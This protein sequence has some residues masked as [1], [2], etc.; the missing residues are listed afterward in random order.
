MNGPYDD[1]KKQAQ[2]IAASSNLKPT[3]H[4]FKPNTLTSAIDYADILDI[5]SY[6]REAAL[7]GRWNVLNPPEDMA[8]TAHLEQKK[9]GFGGAAWRTFKSSFGDMLDNWFDMGTYGLNSGMAQFDNNLREIIPDFDAKRQTI[10]QNPNDGAARFKLGTGYWAMQLGNMG[11]TA[12]MMAGMIGEQ[13]VLWSAT[14]ALTGITGVGG[15]G[16]AALAGTRAASWLNKISKIAKVGLNVTKSIGLPFYQGV[17]EAYI[18]GLEV[19]QEVYTEFLNKP[20]YTQ[21]QALELAQQAVK[22]QVIREGAITG[23]INA[24]QWGALSAFPAMKLGKV[25]TPLERVGQIAGKQSGGRLGQMLEL[26]IGVSGGIERFMGLGIDKIGHRGLRFL[27]KGAINMGSEAIEEGVQNVISNW[28]H[29]DILKQEGFNYEH[30]KFVDSQTIDEMIGGALGGALFGI[31]GG[32]FTKIQNIA[33][34]KAVREREAFLKEKSDEMKNY[35]KEFGAESLGL[36]KSLGTKYTNLIQQYAEATKNKD[37]SRALEIADEIKDVKE[38]IKKAQMN[39]A[40]N[41]ALQ[42]IVADLN[43]QGTENSWVE[44]GYNQIEAIQGALEEYIKVFDE[45]KANNQNNPFLAS[46]LADNETLSNAVQ[47]LKSLE[48]LDSNNLV[49]DREVLTDMQKIYGDSKTTFNNAIEN[50]A[51]YYDK[52]NADTQMAVDYTKENMILGLYEESIAESNTRLADTQRELEELKTKEEERKAKKGK[53]K[54]ANELKIKELEGTIEAIEKDISAAEEF[55]DAVGKDIADL[56]NPKKFEEYRRKKMFE[57]FDLSDMSK[58][59]NKYLKEYVDELE[60]NAKTEDEKA[61]AEKAREFLDRKIK[62]EGKKGKKE[63]KKQKEAENFVGDDIQVPQAVVTEE[64]LQ[65][66]TTEEVVVEEENLEA[67]SI[68]EEQMRIEE[69]ASIIDDSTIEEIDTLLRGTADILNRGINVDT[70]KEQLVKLEE[71]FETLSDINDNTYNDRI[72]QL[73]YYINNINFILI[74]D[75]NISNMID[76]SLLSFIKGFIPNPSAVQIRSIIEN[77]TLNIDGTELTTGI[78]NIYFFANQPQLKEIVRNRIEKIVKKDQVE[79]SEQE[80]V[81]DEMSE[82]VDVIAESQATWDGEAFNIAFEQAFNMYHTPVSGNGINTSTKGP[83]TIYTKRKRGWSSKTKS[84]T[85]TMTRNVMQLT[86]VFDKIMGATEERLRL[87]GIKRTPTFEDYLETCSLRQDTEFVIEH[88]AMYADMWNI[89]NGR[90]D[91]ATELIGRINEYMLHVQEVQAEVT[92]TQVEKQVESQEQITPQIESK[93][94][95]KDEKV[96]P[97]VDVHSVV[98][99]KEQIKKKDTRVAFYFVDASKNQYVISPDGKTKSTVR[100]NTLRDGEHFILD[101]EFIVDELAKTN[102]NLEL[103][104][105]IPTAEDLQKHKA[106]EYPT[107]DGQGVPVIHDNYF[108]YYA[109]LGINRNT[110]ESIFLPNLSTPDKIPHGLKSQFGMFMTSIPM[111]IKYESNEGP[112][113]LGQVRGLNQLSEFSVDDREKIIAQRTAL[114]T[115]NGK[116]VLTGYDQ[117]SVHTRETA[118]FGNTRSALKD[119][120]GLTNRIRYTSKVRNIDDTAAPTVVINNEVHIFELF[121]DDDGRMRKDRNGLPTTVIEDGYTYLNGKKMKV[122][123]YMRMTVAEDPRGAKTSAVDTYEKAYNHLK[124]ASIFTA[125][126]QLNQMNENLLNEEGKAIIAFVQG[127]P[128]LSSL[129]IQN[130]SINKNN[131]KTI[132]GQVDTFLTNEMDLSSDGTKFVSHFNAFLNYDVDTKV[133]QSQKLFSSFLN[134]QK[135]HNIQFKDSSG[136]TQTRT[137]EVMLD[138]IQ[139]L[140]DNSDTNPYYIGRFK[141]PNTNKLFIKLSLDIKHKKGENYG[142]V[143]GPAF[144]DFTEIEGRLDATRDSDGNM[145][146]LGYLSDYVDKWS[147]NQKLHNIKGPNGHTTQTFGIQPKVYYEVMSKDNVK[148]ETNAYV[149][150]LLKGNKQITPIQPATSEQVVQEVVE[151]MVKPAKKKEVTPKKKTIKPVKQGQEENAVGQIVDTSTKDTYTSLVNAVKEA[152]L[153]NFAEQVLENENLRII[154]HGIDNN[155]K[156]LIKQL[157]EVNGLDAELLEYVHAIPGNEVSVKIESIEGFN[158]QLP[159][160]DNAVNFA[161]DVYNLQGINA[162]DQYEL[163]QSLVPIV[164]QQYVENHGAETIKP[165]LI[166]QIVSGLTEDIAQIKEDTQKKFED[167]KAEKKFNEALKVKSYINTLNLL[168]EDNINLLLSPNGLLTQALNEQIVVNLIEEDN[169]FEVPSKS[170]DNIGKSNLERSGENSLSAAARMVLASIKTDKVNK[171]GLPIYENAREVYDNLVDVMVTSSNNIDEVI[172][173]VNIA[174]QQA[175]SLQ[176]RNIYAQLYKILDDA[177]N[178]KKNIMSKKILNGLIVKTHLNAADM[179]ITNVKINKWSD[180]MTGE[181]NEET[182]VQ[183]WNA[184]LDDLSVAKMNEM[185]DMFYNNHETIIF[186]TN[187]TTGA[188]TSQIAWDNNKLRSTKETLEGLQNRFE[189]Q[190]PTQF[191]R[192]YY[193]PIKLLIA[194]MGFNISDSTLADNEILISLFSKDKKD[195]LGKLI[196]D[197]IN[198]VAIQEGNYSVVQEGKTKVLQN[199]NSAF[200]TLMEIESENEGHI[201]T[202]AYIGEKLLSGALQSTEIYDRVQQLKFALDQNKTNAYYYTLQKMQTAKNHIL[203]AAEYFRK[204]GNN[205]AL[206]NLLDTFGPIFLPPEVIRN[207]EIKENSESIDKLS[208]QEYLI[209]AF[210]YLNQI[211]KTQPC[212]INGKD[213]GFRNGYIFL[214]TISDKGQMVAVQMPLLDITGADSTF[215]IVDGKL[216]LGLGNN[217][218]HLLTDQLFKSEVSRM[219]HLENNKKTLTSKTLIKSNFFFTTLEDFNNVMVKNEKKEIVPLLSYLQSNPHLNIAQVMALTTEEGMNVNQRVDSIVT[220]YFNDKLDEV[221][222]V[223]LNKKEN[224]AVL[225]DVKGV[226]ADNGLVSSQNGSFKYE[227]MDKKFLDSRQVKGDIDGVKI[228]KK[229]REVMLTSMDAIINNVLGQKTI[230]DLFMDSATTFVKAVPEFNSKTTSE[231][232]QAQVSESYKLFADNLKKRMAMMIAP[233]YKQMNSENFWDNTQKVMNE[234]LTLS[235]GKTI[236]NKL[237]KVI[238]VKDRIKVSDS[239]GTLIKLYYKDKIG[240][241]QTKIDELDQLFINIQDLSNR[242]KDVTKL[243][244]RKDKIV[245][246]LKAA[247]PKIAAFCEIDSSDGQTYCTWNQYLNFQYRM[248]EITMEDYERLDEMMTRLEAGERYSKLKVEEREFL[249]SFFMNSL[250]T[251][252]TGNVLEKDNNG[253]SIATKGYYIKTSVFPLLP[254]FTQGTKLDNVRKVM[255]AT[256]TQDGKNYIPTLLT[257]DSSIKAGNNI[258]TINYAT[259]LKNDSSKDMDAINKAT[260]T[261]NS[262]YYRLQQATDTHITDFLTKGQQQTINEGVQ[263]N[264]LK[265]SNNIATSLTYDMPGNEL[266]QVIYA[267]NKAFP[268]EKMEGLLDEN[269]NTMITGNMLERLDNWL[270]KKRI[271][272]DLDRLLS[273]LKGKTEIQ[274]DIARLNKEKKELNEQFRQVR[275]F[276]EINDDIN[277]LKEKRRNAYKSINQWKKGVTPTIVKA[278]EMLREEIEKDTIKL[279][280]LYDES[281]ERKGLVSQSENL[282]ERIDELKSLNEVAKNETSDDTTQAMYNL[283]KDEIIKRKLPTNLLEQIKIVEHDGKKVFNVSLF[284][285][286][287]QKQ[288]SDLLFSL[289][290]NSVIQ[291][292]LPGQAHYVV[293]SSELISKRKAK[294]LSQVEPNEIVFI[295]DHSLVNGELGFVEDKVTG[296]IKSQ[297]LLP[298]HFS[299]KQP[300]GTLK[301]IDLFDKEGEW[302]IEKDGRYILNEEKFDKS[303]LDMFTFRIPSSSSAMAN[304]VE[305]VGFIPASYGDIAIVNKE[306]IK[307]LGEDFDIDKRYIYKHYFD[308]KD[309]KFSKKAFNINDTKSIKNA[310]ID[311]YHSVYNTTNE[312]FK[313]EFHKTL[314]TD[315][316]EATANKIAELSNKNQKNSYFDMLYNMKTMKNGASALTAV[317]VFALA[318]KVHALYNRGGGFVVNQGLVVPGKNGIKTIQQLYKFTFGNKTVTD[319]KI[320]NKLAMD[321]VTVIADLFNADLQSAVDNGKLGIIEKI[322]LTNHTINAYLFLNYIGANPYFTKNDVQYRASQIFLAQPILRR[323]SQLMENNNS[324]FARS[325]EADVLRTLISEQGIKIDDKIWN[326]LSY[327]DKI[328]EIRWNLLKFFKLATLNED[329]NLKVRQWELTE[330]SGGVST[331][332]DNVYSTDKYHEISERLTAD[333]LYNQLENGAKQHTQ[334]FALVKFMEFNHKGRQISDISGLLNR[335]KSTRNMFDLMTLKEDLKV[336]FKSETISDINTMIGDVTEYAEE[337]GDMTNVYNLDGTWFRI[338]PITTEGSLIMTLIDAAE[339]I[340]EPHFPYNSR[341]IS[342]AMAD[343]VKF[344]W[345]GQNKN[346][347]KINELRKKIVADMAKFFERNRDANLANITQIGYDELIQQMFKD[348]ESNESFPMFVAKIKHANLS[349]T[350]NE[351]LKPFMIRKEDTKTILKTNLINRDKQT[352]IRMR[353]IFID[354][355]KDNSEIIDKDGN[356]IYWNNEKLTYRQLAQYFVL[357]SK[358]SNSQGGAIGFSNI[359]PQKYLD[360]VGFPKSVRNI[361]SNINS[362]L[363]GIKVPSIHAYSK[364]YAQHHPDILQDESILVNKGT[365]ANSEFNYKGKLWTVESIMADTD[366]SVGLDIKTKV[367]ALEYI[368]SFQ[369]SEIGQGTDS[370]GQDIILPFISLKTSDR[371]YLIFE[372]DVSND[373]GITTWKQ[374]STL[375]GFGVSEYIFN[376]N[377]VIGMDVKGTLKEHVIS[378]VLE[379]VVPIQSVKQDNTVPQTKEMKEIG[380]MLGKLTANEQTISLDKFLSSKQIQG[381]FA[382]EKAEMLKFLQD[383]GIDD[384]I[385]VPFDQNHLAYSPDSI[386]G[387]L[388]SKFDAARS[389]LGLKYQDVP[390]TAKWDKLNIDGKETYVI[391]I[392]TPDFMKSINKEVMADIILEEILHDGIGREFAKYNK[393]EDMPMEM[394]VS[395]NLHQNFQKKFEKV[396]S[397]YPNQYKYYTKDI[398]EFSAA[399]ELHEDFRNAVNEVMNDESFVDKFIRAFKSF[400]DKL[401]GKEQNYTN[402]VRDTTGRILSKSYSQNNNLYQKYLELVNKQIVDETANFQAKYQELVDL[403]QKLDVLPIATVDIS[404]Q[405]QIQETELTIELLDDV[406]A[407]GVQ[408]GSIDYYNVAGFNIQMGN[409]DQFGHEAIYQYREL[410]DKMLGRTSRSIRTLRNRARQLGNNNPSWDT[411]H[412]SVERLMDRQAAIEKE[413]T[414]VEN[415]E[416]GDSHLFL[417]SVQ[418]EIFRLSENIDK[419]SQ[420]NNEFKGISDPH[421]LSDVLGSFQ[422]IKSFIEELST[423][424]T[425][426]RLSDR[427]ND[428]LVDAADMIHKT[429]LKLNSLSEKLVYHLLL[430]DNELKQGIFKGL[431]NEELKQALEKIIQEEIT[432]N[433]GTNSFFDRFLG[434]LSSFKHDL[435]HTQILGKYI[436]N[437]ILEHNVVAKSYKQQMKEMADK[438]ADFKDEKFLET[439][440]GE[441]TGDLIDYFSP[442]WK[443]QLMYFESLSYKSDDPLR[444][445]NDRLKWL[446]DKHVIDFRRIPEVRD[447]K[448]TKLDGSETTFFEKYNGVYDLNYEDSAMNSYV[449]ELKQKLGKQYDFF[450]R[451]VINQLVE[452]ERYNERLT[453]D[454][455]FEKYEIAGKASPWLF[456]GTQFDKEGNMLSEAQELQV[457]IPFENGTV[458][459]A[460]F[461]SEMQNITVIPQDIPKYKNAQFDALTDAELDLWRVLRDIYANH[462]N[463]IYTDRYNDDLS[464]A[465]IEQ[466]TFETFSKYGMKKG[467][468][469]LKAKGKGAF[470][471]S[472]YKEAGFNV[473]KNYFDSTKSDIAEMIEIL[474]NQN[475]NYIETLAK[476]YKVDETLNREEQIFK[477]AHRANLGNFSTDILKS[478]AALLD[479]AAQQAA[480]DETAATGYLLKEANKRKSG[481]DS[482]SYKKIDTIYRRIV[483]GEGVSAGRVGQDRF[484]NVS[485]RKNDDGTNTILQNIM[486][487]FGEIPLLNKVL[488]KDVLINLSESEKL[489]RDSIDELLKADSFDRDIKFTAYEDKKKVKYS[490]NNETETYQTTYFEGGKKIETE[491]SEEGFRLALQD[492]LSDMQKNLGV[493]LTLNGILDGIFSAIIFKGLGYNPKGGFFNRIEGKLSTWKMDATGRYWTVGN[494]MKFQNMLFM[495]NSRKILSKIVGGDKMLGDTLTI[496]S[497]FFEQSELMQDKKNE[498]DRNMKVSKR[499]YEKAKDMLNPYAFAVDLPE[500]K[501]QGIPAGAVLMDFKIKNVVTGE[502]VNIFDAD[503]QQFNCYEVGENGKF[504]LKEEYRDEA[505]ISNWEKFEPNYYNT[506]YSY[507]NFKHKAMFALSRT[508]GNYK[509]TDT[510]LIVSNALTRPIMMFKRWMPEHARVKWG[511]DKGLNLF[512]GDKNDKGLYNTLWKHPE[513]ALGTAGVNLGLTYVNPIMPMLML[514]PQLGLLGY[515]LFKGIQSIGRNVDGE[516]RSLS[517]IL[518]YYGQAFVE[519]ANMGLNLVSRKQRIKTK[520][521]DNMLGKRSAFGNTI[522]EEDIKGIKQGAAELGS[523]IVWVSILFGVKH[524]LWSMIKKIDDD[525]ERTFEE[526]KKSIELKKLYNFIQNQGGRIADTFFMF[527]NPMEVLTDMQN[528]SLVIYAQSWVKAANGALYL[529]TKD[530]GTKMLDL[531]PLPRIFYKGNKIQFWKEDKINMQNY[532]PVDKWAKG[533]DYLLEAHYKDVRPAIVDDILDNIKRGK[534]VPYDFKD[535]DVR[536]SDDNIKKEIRK[537]LPAKKDFDNYRELLDAYYDIANEIPGHSYLAKKY[538]YWMIR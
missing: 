4:P 486:S 371:R 77:L 533:R 212:N 520:L 108:D 163:A 154:I 490:Y 498:F 408:M 482:I 151:N 186:N 67:G 387:Q 377:N 54:E 28:I 303:L 328:E 442:D 185:N 472:Q 394:K 19:G 324:K 132:L 509:A 188:V 256:E 9:E 89:V 47:T 76:E 271:E 528:A 516:V 317:S 227:N 242:N 409:Y 259:V 485:A 43:L 494:A 342:S 55:A 318:T 345:Q 264:S 81:Y 368:S 66:D 469:M 48:I 21:A 289:I 123:R 207:A 52:V 274:E 470:F 240:E 237:M 518:P 114:L 249:D 59:N 382:E 273:R 284:T 455:T 193:A 61:K 347:T 515:G 440:D 75:N 506:E 103:I 503:K 521:I 198:E 504:R 133:Q 131:I 517:L 36:Q 405:P 102:G 511:T 221:I 168:T 358:L 388:K 363:P 452:Y 268:N 109:K 471:T 437:K 18:N 15:I 349:E 262:E 169:Q 484:L 243:E 359:I 190:E 37:G 495:S 217:I 162:I 22:M 258:N 366:F 106:I 414:R 115:G 398:L 479:M 253:N 335:A 32:G 421:V 210:S 90:E 16:G 389:S 424:K 512:V 418:K 449:D 3:M 364:Q 306:H 113:V 31:L 431:N 49:S 339:K 269:G 429:E 71:A 145:K 478:T 304:I 95:K 406:L 150:E 214:P 65:T 419:L 280:E 135:I 439:I 373:K 476:K 423:Q 526:D 134:L 204:E 401:F 350:M 333:A 287:N 514:L 473:R 235:N 74:D 156:S 295:G 464:Y 194:D 13:A 266:M 197:F 53:G 316:E 290:Q 128:D 428:S 487:G 308:Y 116:L 146:K 86:T 224:G 396:A 69:V 73:Q 480:R 427:A 139:K 152:N 26:N 432:D 381:L 120:N 241:Y 344:S 121:K 137:I 233:G 309:G 475:D 502:M 147:I 12:A 244:E 491:V 148:I 319:V 434:A 42:S 272:A 353:G 263:P 25:A 112:I 305:V 8:M 180:W 285:S 223:T 94:E 171:F 367:D 460:S 404:V 383:R 336:M 390:I 88:A 107:I 468:E 196:L 24:F 510:T 97:G 481:E 311:I 11:T 374:I 425:E 519:M 179:R 392:N 453:M 29:R 351:F 118:E 238:E 500:W 265:L 352:S 507:E 283:L 166:R 360:Y 286:E 110:I 379:P 91:D 182:A 536:Q 416:E 176:K 312:E 87:Q 299:I 92:P 129:G 375:G 474:N 433:K 155:Q 219:L 38:R 477:I 245:A 130:K 23:A 161:D 178:N 357:Y 187:E 532:T 466:S 239:L 292:K 101:N 229:L 426:D 78:T 246:E 80:Q 142:N 415:L 493:D 56:T 463:P 522:T 84:T 27:A 167:L 529:D 85:G 209:T 465:K 323:Y 181:V 534:D 46:K 275:S 173:K 158:I 538:H 444:T 234:S 230:L 72:S 226:L 499:T 399:V 443:R 438:I 447:Y 488:N 329:A 105:D 201:I 199:A 34:T 310:M 527:S 232:W 252:Y 251:V 14:V 334:L 111:Q 420:L 307:T 149:S 122:F 450:I 277:F 228:N 220:E 410:L 50:F 261:L 422:F 400:I 222:N 279:Q 446:R 192:D 138:R 270:H 348:T 391:A 356:P 141:T 524:A 41:F 70:I 191:L 454:D 370:Q 461:Y 337:P 117:N 30:I 231:G 338:N 372:K 144:I 17:R 6:Y 44:N 100:E 157:L 496:W 296:V 325:N 247:F 327:Q 314:S 456:M 341:F 195:G 294:N 267:F 332:I 276:K 153:E 523:K 492:H 365:I 136:K 1:L 313:K 508:Q 483:Q 459:E 298:S 282:N 127:L 457:T 361:T 184:N 445:T 278:K 104:V 537:R 403:E 10:Y 63:K 376:H 125:L 213:Y 58:R 124:Y 35:F 346:T 99:K 177:N 211:S 436:D 326:S 257:F 288:F 98:Q 331:V 39:G 441:L 2:S 505:N 320:G 330:N 140:F 395:A 315:I 378:H 82:I 174:G 386:Q 164:L 300:D 451:G 68:V 170:Q 64:E 126:S 281:N 530:I 417:Q 45:A 513:F 5:P 205:V 200:K 216:K 291:N 165:K 62:E 402:Y 57:N 60:R 159:E 393:I 225:Y 435:P 93:V 411:I 397:K 407:E 385:V 458:R 497:Q 297:I 51:H 203:K 189:G 248:G 343:I 172:S 384:I 143:Q 467:I 175:K 462:I 250:K 293:T 354:L 236:S 215:K 302:I 83:T 413:I 119:A 362:E 218:I 501:N 183:L 535:I 531:T 525:D 412:D 20:G 254:H 489:M 255:Q 160:I 206:Y 369:S 208:E 7:Q 430:T 448:F 355:L 321:G 79:K 40:I 202:P 33:N 96:Q 322:N 380:V 340:V 301:L 260:T